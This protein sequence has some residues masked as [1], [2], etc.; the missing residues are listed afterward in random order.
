[1]LKIS[2]QRDSQGF[3]W[4][5]TDMERC[6]RRSTVHAAQCKQSRLAFLL[7]ELH[8]AALASSVQADSAGIH[9]PHRKNRMI[10]QGSINPNTSDSNDK[11]RIHHKPL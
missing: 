8:S 10:K 3:G 9:H 2:L 1:M 5:S 4:Q 11:F 6:C 7:S